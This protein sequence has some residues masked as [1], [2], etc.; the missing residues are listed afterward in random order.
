[1]G[2]GVLDHPGQVALG[3]SVASRSSAPDHEIGQQVEVSRCAKRR[4]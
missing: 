3:S 2:A 4:L 1:M